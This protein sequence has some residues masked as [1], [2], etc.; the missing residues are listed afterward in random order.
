MV[1]AVSSLSRELFRHRRRCDIH[2]AWQRNLEKAGA[3]G[4]SGTTGRSRKVNRPC[5]TASPTRR[6]CCTNPRKGLSGTGSNATKA[7][8]GAIRTSAPALK[9]LPKPIAWYL[10]E[11]AA[12]GLTGFQPA[13]LRDIRLETISAA[14]SALTMRAPDRQAAASNLL[15]FRACDRM[16]RIQSGTRHP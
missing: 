15:V 1:T 13:A 9:D 2:G 6:G 10:G 7:I 5:A 16:P 4:R 8:Q 12:V 14:G 3:S 11:D